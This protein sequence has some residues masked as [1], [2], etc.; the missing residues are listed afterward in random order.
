ML[1]TIYEDAVEPAVEAVK[2]RHHVVIEFDI[3]AD[4]YSGVG[5]N[6]NA[7]RALVGEMFRGQA[8]WPTDRTIT[9]E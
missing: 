8:D 5:L 2:K 3:D 6:S 9:V 4:N 1:Q 7:V